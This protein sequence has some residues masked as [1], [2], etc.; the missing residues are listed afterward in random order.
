MRDALRTEASR[1]GLADRVRFL[2]RVSEGELRTLYAAADLFVLPTVAYE[3]FGMATVEALA[4]GT[5]VVGTSVG[6]TPELLEPL[7]P[8]LLAPEPTGPALAAA[9]RWV[10]GNT[11]DAFRARCAAYARERFD[12]EVAIEG[13]EDALARASEL[14]VRSRG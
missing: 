5:P 9:I 10:L 13:W 11:S 8:R 12:W 3:G 1:L 6:A 14:S 2:G 7:E 4:S